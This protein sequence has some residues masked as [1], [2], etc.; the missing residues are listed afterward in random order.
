MGVGFGLLLAT[1]VTIVKAV[2]LCGGVKFFIRKAFLFKIQI[3]ITFL[4]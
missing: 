3:L 2:E 1:T 4:A